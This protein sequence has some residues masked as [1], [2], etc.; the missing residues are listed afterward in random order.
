VSKTHFMCGLS[1]LRMAEKITNNEIKLWNNFNN[2]SKYIEINWN[3]EIWPWND[4][5]EDT[6]KIYV[7][8]ETVRMI[9]A[10]D[11]DMK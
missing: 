11:L 8:K 2:S 7:N 1:D 6:R 10:R 3:Y 4:C 5:E 9:L